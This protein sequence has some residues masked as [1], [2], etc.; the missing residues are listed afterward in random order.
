MRTL[1]ALIASAGLVGCV[2]SVDPGSNSPIIDDGSGVPETDNPAGADLTPAK[3]LF[4]DNV[5]DILKAKC[6]SDGCHAQAGTGG[7]ITKFVATN[8]ADGWTVATNYNALVGT[9]TTAAPVLAY[10][11]AL[12]KGASYTA[13]E[14]TK[15]EAWLAKELELRQGQPQGP[16]QGET[17][18]Q[19]ADRV[20]NQFA[21]CMKLEDFQATNMAAA[22]ANINSNEGQCKRCHATGESSFIAN[23][24]AP[25]SFGVL[26][27]KKMYFLQYFTVNLSGGA[28]AAK[29]E[30]NQVSFLGVYNRTAPHLTHPTFPYPT[31]AGVTALKAFYDKTILNVQGGLCQ[32]KALENF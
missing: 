30:P 21:G 25:T 27:V 19:A 2:G 28:T 4:D 3:K 10:P 15:I 16:A 11:A 12:H 20:M 22:W 13:D 6:G 8:K 17:L 24:D 23:Q 29:V 31:N 7:T 32:P 14:K 5:Y 26:S 18:S 9:Y 1:L